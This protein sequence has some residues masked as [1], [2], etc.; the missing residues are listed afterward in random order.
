MKWMVAVLAGVV[1]GGCAS[2][3]RYIPGDFAY[4]DISKGGV[5]GVRASSDGT[6]KIF[7]VYADCVEGECQYVIR[8]ALKG[9]VGNEGLRWRARAGESYLASSDTYFNSPDEFA[10]AT[11]ALEVVRSGNDFSDEIRIKVANERML[12]LAS[13]ANDLKA[14]QVKAVNSAKLAADVESNRQIAEV[15]TRTG[16]QPMLT[17]RNQKDFNSLATM[18]RGL[19]IEEF[20]G[21]FV[22]AGDGDYRVSQIL[23]GEVILTSLTNP[24][25]FPMISI[26]TDK[27]ALEGQ[28]WSAVSKGPLQF[29][30]PRMYKT[31]IGVE[32]QVL[33][34][35]TI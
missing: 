24:S 32:R 4:E 5:V 13:A 10:S 12:R 29:A 26:V 11:A 1:L 20:V 3:V 34:F 25:L 28:A 19:G 6:G 9:G 7:D 21:K 18:F 8:Q 33:V 14:A 17:G 31:A 23:E 27:Q 16:V 30:G 15:A 35:K 2:G 22:W